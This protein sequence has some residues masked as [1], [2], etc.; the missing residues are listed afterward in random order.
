MSF[1]SDSP[2]RGSFPGSVPAPVKRKKKLAARPKVA[3]VE[4]VK[5]AIQEIQPDAIITTKEVKEFIATAAQAGAQGAHDEE[6]RRA[7]RTFREDQ[8]DVMRFVALVVCL[9]R[10]SLLRHG[11]PRRPV[12]ISFRL[13]SPARPRMGMRHPWGLTT[14]ERK[15]AKGRRQKQGCWWTVGPGQWSN[16]DGR[17]WIMPTPNSGSV[18]WWTRRYSLPFDSIAGVADYLCERALEWRV[19]ERGS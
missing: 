17:A 18:T 11:N 10:F 1:P 9:W 6:V 16:P 3:K 15:A 14:E 8:K 7:L 19:T 5:Q 12:W 13:S 2:F 4:Q